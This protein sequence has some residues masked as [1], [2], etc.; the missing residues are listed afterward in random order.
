[1]NYS[2]EI[3]KFDFVKKINSESLLCGRKF[4]KKD[5]LYK[6]LLE[7]S[8]LGIYLLEESSLSDN[9][10]MY[11]LDEIKCKAFII[12]EDNLIASFPMHDIN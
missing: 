7:S 5:N 4:L 9:I 2:A 3:I 11:S 6:T 10:M 12:K 1:M 8:L